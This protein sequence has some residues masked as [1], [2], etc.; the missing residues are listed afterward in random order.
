V[1]ENSK[2]DQP[3]GGRSAAQENR[4]EGSGTDAATLKVRPAGDPSA[5]STNL[6]EVEKNIKPRR[7]W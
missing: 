7:D 1:Q 2:T 5:K 4:P 6:T 3:A